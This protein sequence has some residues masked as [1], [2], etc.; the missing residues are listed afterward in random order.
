MDAD[1]ALARLSNMVAATTTPALS[2]EDVDALLDYAIRPDGTYDLR[3]A[4][5]EGWRW[6][7]GKVAGGFTFSADGV[8]VDKSMLLEHC[9]GMVKQYSTGVRTV[10][11]DTGL[12]PFETD[13]YTVRAQQ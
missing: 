8:A 13:F 6:K 5:A 4:A 1:M 9:L 10:T 2:D 7:A 12:S 3:R 11:V